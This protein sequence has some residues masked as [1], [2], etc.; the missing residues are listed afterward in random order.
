MTDAIA[1]PSAA[2]AAASLNFD[3][4]YES[5]FD[6]VYR[7]VACLAGHRDV[8]DLAQEVFLVVHRRLSDFEARA[9]L[10]T[11]LFRIAYRVVG[12]HIRRERLRRFILGQLA[13][14]P[15]G[16]GLPHAT[17]TPLEG[18]GERQAVIGAVGRLSYKKRSVLLL[19][20]LEGHSCQRIAEM[21]ELPTNTVYTRL[22]HARRE[23]AHMLGI[24][25]GANR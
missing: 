9:Q 25:A 14:E 18:H 24:N 5:H 12:A 15:T 6:F 22:Y 3:E 4:V 10:T 17:T 19:H 11:W 7:T 23:L 20:V 2:G 1:R 16:H 8:D 13:L 21:L